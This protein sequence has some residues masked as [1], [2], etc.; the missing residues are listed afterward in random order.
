MQHGVSGRLLVRRQLLISA[1]INGMYEQVGERRGN[2]YMT[3]D[4]PAG[5]T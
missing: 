1:P 5:C 2:L 3:V 4:F